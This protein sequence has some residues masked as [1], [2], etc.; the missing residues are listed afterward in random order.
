MHLDFG[1]AFWALAA[2]S[3]LAA[4]VYGLAFLNRPPSL[5]RAGVK[6]LFMA[7]L[8][9]AFIAAHAP[10]PLILALGAAALG[11][12]FLAFDKTWTL[13]LGIL[14]FLIMQLLYALMFFGLWMLSGDNSPLW[15]RYAMMAVLVIVTLGFLVWIGP[16]LKW[17]A[18]GVVPYS[19]AIAAMACMAMWLPWAGWP[20]MLGV[21][22]FVVSDG[23][24]SAELFK[25]ASDAPA[26]RITAPIVWWS[27]AGAQ[28]LIVW[29]IVRAAE[30]MQ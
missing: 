22:S 29:G 26:R 15:P 6:T 8:A 2:L 17:L 16:K 28:A 13:G 14:S 9:G 27:Y 25:L 3:A 19:L 7:A 5:L 12:F 23:V 10:A 24:L 11:D 21:V 20:A 18:L 30:V 4:L 1:T